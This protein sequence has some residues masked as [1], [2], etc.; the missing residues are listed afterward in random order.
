M[1]SVLLSIFFF[2]QPQ[3]LLQKDFGDVPMLHIKDFTMYELDPF[4]MKTLMLGEEAFRY[5]DRYT[6]DNIEHTDH[7]KT[8][9]SHLR[10]DFGLYKNDTLDLDGNVRF[11]RDD[12]LNYK[13]QKA[14]YYKKKG[15]FV[16]DTDYVLSQS[17]NVL[18]GT[19]LD[20]N[21]LSGKIHSKNVNAIYT[22]KEEQ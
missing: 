6:V 11:L 20:H 14:L 15:L 12:G 21:N 13:T 16:T 1:I 8:H 9:I 19:Y 3:K 2:F 5:K 10:A 17:A 22:I 7:S 18:R 4:G